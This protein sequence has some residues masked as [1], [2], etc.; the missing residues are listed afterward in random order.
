MQLN[1]TFRE[2]ITAIDIGNSKIT[3]VIARARSKTQWHIAGI[4]HHVS[5]GLNK[6]SIVSLEALSYAIA[7]A[8]HNAEQ[9]ARQIIN[10]VVISISP[11]L[12]TSE[13]ITMEIDLNGATV[14]QEHINSLVTSAQNSLKREQLAVHVLPIKYK[15]D[16]LSNIID[17]QGMIG[18]SLQATLY[19]AVSPTAHVR[20]LIKSVEM[21]RLEVVGVAS[22]AIAAAIVATNEEEKAL[23]ASFIELGAATTSIVIFKHGK[24]IFSATIPIGSQHITNDIAYVFSMSLAMAE[25]YKTLYGFIGANQQRGT[26]EVFDINQRS[27]QIS[28]PKLHQVI[29]ARV[30][31][32][33]SLLLRNLKA[34]DLIGQLGQQVIISGGG[35]YLSG[36]GDYIARALNLPVRITEQFYS[37]S[38]MSS[39]II[40]RIPNPAIIATSFGLLH[41]AWAASLPL[42]KNDNKSTSWNNKIMELFR[43]V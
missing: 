22:A 37:P 33:F 23:G 28:Q 9:M 1:N 19:R 20:N 6:G 36:L 14:D 41:Y 43:I 11:A 39:D 30:H 15:V 38:I 13:N 21:C 8:V 4:G 26:L 10:Q 2:T 16:S 17:P 32:I 27:L 18:E 29:N 5:R 12:I 25:R 3:C 24:I 42:V 7:E 40:T 35:A 34:H 31:E